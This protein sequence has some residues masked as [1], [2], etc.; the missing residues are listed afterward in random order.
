MAYS[1]V[2][3][4]DVTPE[5]VR[6]VLRQF[7]PM[8]NGKRA[9]V[10]RNLFPLRFRRRYLFSKIDDLDFQK[11]LV[12]LPLAFQDFFLGAKLLKCPEDLLL[13]ISNNSAGTVLQVPD[14]M[15]YHWKRCLTGKV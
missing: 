2:S 5:L 6:A 12:K 15:I 1:D 4:V 11:F 7:G 9:W 14:E 10:V 8:Q 3:D 13:I